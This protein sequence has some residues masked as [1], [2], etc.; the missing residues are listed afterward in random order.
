MLYDTTL[1]LGEGVPVRP[2][3]PTRVLVRNAN[4][5]AIKYKG[6]GDIELKQKGVGN[7]EVK[8]VGDLE[9]K[10]QSSGGSG[11]SWYDGR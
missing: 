7:V 6:V 2:L 3:S 8:D 1:I 10:S 4:S 9:Q 11:F 5:R